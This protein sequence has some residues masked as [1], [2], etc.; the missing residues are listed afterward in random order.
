VRFDYQ[1]VDPVR[2]RLIIA[3]MNDASVVA[4]ALG[5]GAVVRVVSNVPV[6][7]GVAVASELARVF[8]T[9]SPHSLVVLDAD[10]LAEVARVPTGAGPDGV[11]WDTAHHIVGVS[12]QSDG[13]L[14]LVFDAGRGKR[15]S[16]HL[17]RETG[18]VAFDAARGWFW[19]AVERAAPP[20]ALVAVD[21]LT[22]KVVRTVE[23]A[24]CRGAH[25]VLLHPD[26]ATAFV[27]CEDDARIAR[28]ALAESGGPA[29]VLAPS[30]ADPDV[31][32]LDPELGWLYVAAESGD[33][34]VFDVTR[35]GLVLV[36]REHPADG[37]HSVA[38]DPATHRVYF[39]LA[40]G[41]NGAPT[42]RIMVPSGI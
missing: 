2:R 14:S 3:H 15:S 18:N 4:V 16:V 32:A 8:V 6:P 24:G 41:P 30:G 12:D 1:A 22:A 42:L 34:T 31:L 36:G 20:D 40:R 37:S 29:S 33:L 38:V 17:G 11:A 23:L 7:R 13:A 39:P 25:G 5:D 9:S 19:V 21:P 26:G 35:P 10:S 27:A 28:V